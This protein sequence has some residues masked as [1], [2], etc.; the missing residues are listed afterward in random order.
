MNV[1]RVIASMDPASGG[2]CQGI[3]NAIP[4]LQKLGV[5]N[6]VVCL[7]SPGAAY[8]KNDSFT[9]HAIGPSKGPWQSGEHLIPWLLSNLNR[10]D[11]IVV[12][13]LWLYHGY[14]VRK[15]LKKFKEAMHVKNNGFGMPKL[16]VMP[17]GMLDPYF[18]K[19]EG[20]KLKAFRNWLYW[21]IIE[22]KLV[23]EADGVLFTCETE[24]LLARRTFK[25]Y[26]PKKELNVGYGI[27]APS[28]FD[29]S[30]ID[31]FQLKCKGLNN[32][33]YLLF[34]SRIHEKK[35]VDLILNAYAKAI[36][37]AIRNSKVLPNGDARESASFPKLVL[38]GPG[39]DTPFGEKIKKLKETDPLLDNNVFFPGMLSGDAKWGALYGCE[40]FIL[41]SHQENF[42]IAVA[43]A[44]ACGKAV[45]ISDQVNIWR[46]IQ[47]DG[48]G[49]VEEDT[50]EGTQKL[51]KRFANLQ[52][53]ERAVLRQKAY[54]C[55]KN[56]FTIEAA[57]ARFTEAV[58][59][60]VAKHIN[61]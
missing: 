24:L 28:A 46:E 8:I 4:Q 13:G 1:L 27:A 23:N 55:Y 54:N 39:M 43:E 20:R 10:F 30:F 9:I 6:E 29:P 38:A 52:A 3:R 42:G 31:A 14:A 51:I 48:A 16:F 5:K 41:P 11:A 18:Q 49:F 15:A 59:T 61:V 56:Y 45:L 36:R 34:L 44:L 26:K 35:G 53:D 33:P 32:A 12:H 37:E 47:N 21:K 25:P 50:L 57:A 22:S 2:P 7:D 17:H 58:K 60:S 40:F 19:A